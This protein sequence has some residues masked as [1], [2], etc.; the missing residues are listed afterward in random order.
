MPKPNSLTLTASH[1]I[2]EMILAPSSCSITTWSSYLPRGTKCSSSSSYAEHSHSTTSLRGMAIHT[3]LS[4]Q[5]ELVK[6]I[7]L[8]SRLF[9]SMAMMYFLATLSWAQLMVWLA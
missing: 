5:Q 2:W 6:V 9:W 7:F 8:L 3:L 4:G 1:S